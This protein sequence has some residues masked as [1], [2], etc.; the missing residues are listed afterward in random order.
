[1]EGEKGEKGQ[2]G[3]RGIDFMRAVYFEQSPSNG[4]DIY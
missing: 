3:A 2:E 4:S 1:M